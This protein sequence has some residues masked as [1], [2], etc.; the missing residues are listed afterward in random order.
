MNIFEALFSWFLLYRCKFHY[1]LFWQVLIPSN[2]YFGDDRILSEEG[3][4][5]GDP[6]G[7]LL[8]S[9]GI[10]DVM[11]SCESEL[12][13]W[14]LDDGSLLGTPD[15]VINDL[16][17]ILDAADSLG[18]QINPKKCE[19]FFTNDKIFINVCGLCVTV[20]D[21]KTES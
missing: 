10:R 18:L 21:H 15:E 6:L 3:I 12:S 7:P 1:L 4:Q 14:Y 19:V 11:K 16:D 8:F 9:L 5:Q 2:L 17:K 13:V 20:Y